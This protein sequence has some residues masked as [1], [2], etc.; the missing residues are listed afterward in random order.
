MAHNT[1]AFFLF[2]PDFL[3]SPLG[4]GPCCG[5]TWLP[6]LVLRLPGKWPG[7]KRATLRRRAEA[8]IHVNRKEFSLCFR[9]SRSACRYPS[10]ITFS[11]NLLSPFHH[12]G[13]TVEADND[14]GEVV[15]V[16]SYSDMFCGHP[17]PDSPAP[18]D[19][20]YV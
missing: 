14:A 10:D 13:V 4:A 1:F 12:F 18:T 9:S 6:T 8:P 16:S 20:E 17:S 5:D 19:L 7:R 2:S 11:C 15:S 3:L